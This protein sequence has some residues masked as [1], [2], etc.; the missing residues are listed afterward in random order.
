MGLDFDV[1]LKSFEAVD[2]YDRVSTEIGMDVRGTLFDSGGIC[3]LQTMSEGFR[4]ALEGFIYVLNE[5]P[6]VHSELVM[7]AQIAVIDCLVGIY[8][9]AYGCEDQESMRAVED[10]LVGAAQGVY[11]DKNILVQKGIA[12]FSYEQLTEVGLGKTS[13]SRSMCAFSRKS[14][15][16]ESLWEENMKT[17]AY[18][19]DPDGDSAEVY[20]DYKLKTTDRRRPQYHGSGKPDLVP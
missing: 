3:D 1:G 18:F 17:D 11:G 20:G 2:F 4:D 10:F 8:A 13:F 12:E 6:P 19:C 14:P 5:K 16:H 9:D 7:K 15:S